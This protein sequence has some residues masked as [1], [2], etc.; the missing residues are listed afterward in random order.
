M[1]N[2]MF[3]PRMGKRDKPEEIKRSECA[4]LNGPSSSRGF[5]GNWVGDL[6]FHC[7][8]P[9]LCCFLAQRQGRLLNSR[10][11]VPF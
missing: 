8:N 2:M 1:D 10:K 6:R 3:V 4:V 9:L 11:C 5:S 7:F